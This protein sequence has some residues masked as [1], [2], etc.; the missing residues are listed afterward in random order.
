LAEGV[1]FFA[2]KFPFCKDILEGLC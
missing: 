2:E 1:L